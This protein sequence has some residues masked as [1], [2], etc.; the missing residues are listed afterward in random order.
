MGPLLGNMIPITRMTWCTCN[1]TVIDPI[2]DTQTVNIDL[3]ARGP[4]PVLFGQIHQHKAGQVELSINGGPTIEVNPFEYEPS[5]CPTGEWNDWKSFRLE[6]D[7]ADL[8]VGTNTFQWTVGERPPC[9]DG[10][11]LW[12]GFS[13]KTLHIQTDVE[14]ALG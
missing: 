2:G 8:V 11:L 12:D 14:H 13:V 10:P 5:G 4:N 1:A 6:L 9:V 3:D 7:P